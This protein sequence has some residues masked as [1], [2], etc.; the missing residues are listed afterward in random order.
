MT[1][2]VIDDENHIPV[3]IESQILVGSNK[4]AM[5]SFKNL[6]YPLGNVVKKKSK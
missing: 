6:R 4:V 5:T 1:V 3:R 2:W